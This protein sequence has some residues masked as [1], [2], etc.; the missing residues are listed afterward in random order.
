MRFAVLFH[1]ASS[2]PW[3][4]CAPPVESSCLMVH[5]VHVSQLCGLAQHLPLMAKP[6][7]QW[8]K[9]NKIHVPCYTVITI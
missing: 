1:S 2:H 8:Q 3:V 4:H 5:H 6:S 7:F 9:T